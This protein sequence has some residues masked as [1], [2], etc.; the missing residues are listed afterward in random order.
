[1]EQMLDYSV[2]LVALLMIAGIL[3]LIHQLFKALFITP[4]INK[5]RRLLREKDSIQARALLLDALQKQPKRKE[6][7]GLKRQLDQ[8]TAGETS[9]ESSQPPQIP[10]DGEA[11]SVEQRQNA[12]FMNAQN[13]KRDRFWVGTNLACLVLFLCQCLSY[14]ILM[15]EFA[16][17]AAWWAIT[18][19]FSIVFILCSVGITRNIETFPNSYFLYQGLVGLFFSVEYISLYFLSSKIDPGLSVML[20]ILPVLPV[21]ALFC[22]IYRGRT[23]KSRKGDS[24]RNLSEVVYRIL[25][26]TAAVVMSFIAP[27]LKSLNAARA[28]PW[29][30]LLSGYLFS[31]SF[32]YIADY[33][34]IQKEKQPKR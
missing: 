18:M 26:L 6:F 10:S 25:F 14:T 28:L 1:M 17:P 13:R 33:I 32:F 30:F 19:L 29:V 11:D 16:F 34:M 31:F 15:P 22:G 8:R 9:A 23:G 21:I 12:A 27:L 4:R 24:W 5:I 20:R 3:A 2:D 7:I